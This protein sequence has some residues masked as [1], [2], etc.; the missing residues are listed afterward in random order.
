[1]LSPSGPRLP[2]LD[3]AALVSALI[4]VIQ[5]ASAE[6]GFPGE[7]VT[8]AFALPA[9]AYAAV[10]RMDLRET[11]RLRG[12]A[13]RDW[14]PVVAV[15]MGMLP[16][17]AF[18]V[19]GEMI[20]FGGAGWEVAPELE[21]A[22]EIVERTPWFS[23]TILPSAAEELFF[24]GFLLSS[25][26]AR[27]GPG[28]AVAYAA[29]LFGSLHPLLIQFLPVTAL[30][31]VL[32]WLVVRTGSLVPAVIGHLANN[33]AA[34]WLSSAD[35]GAIVGEGGEVALRAAGIGA[36]LWGA[37]RLGRGGTRCQESDGGGSGSA[38]GGASSGEVRE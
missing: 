26:L 1:M 15:S 25:F 27:F 37:W 36:F 35:P 8:L 4:L 24:R 12:I 29:L 30:G 17:S 23:I 3:D 9:V 28:R 20:L 21:R 18:L 10:C 19:E 6:A 31:A 34:V 33:A 7:C 13:G 2:G 22:Q 16:I 14:L 38:R 11:F 32:G 5:G